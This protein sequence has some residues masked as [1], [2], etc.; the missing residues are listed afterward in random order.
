M[1]DHVGVPATASQF[2]GPVNPEDPALLG[3][4]AT[5]P[6]E[7]ALQTAPIKDI[8]MAYGITREQWNQLRV[9][10][11]FVADVRAA[12]EELKKEGMSFRMKARLQADELLKKSWQMIHEPFDRVP[13]NVKADLIK[14]TVRAAGLEPDS[15]GGVGGGGSGNNLQINIVL[16]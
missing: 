14:F 1:E 2:Y 7:V 13:A 11:Q 12:H 16:G 6:I 4:P 3:Y 5:L 8:C 9:H 10:P 15:K